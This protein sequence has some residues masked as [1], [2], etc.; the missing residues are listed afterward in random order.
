ML[1]SLKLAA[2]LIV[3]AASSASAFIVVDTGDN[4]PDCEVDGTLVVITDPT[5]ET[6]CDG[7]GTAPP[8]PCVCDLDAAG[9]AAFVW[10]YRPDAVLISAFPACAAGN[11]GDHLSVLDPMDSADCTVGSGTYAPHDCTCDGATST[12]RAGWGVQSEV[13]TTAIF[14]KDGPEV[15]IGTITPEE[16]LD[17][18]GANNVFI[19]IGCTG[20]D[21]VAGVKLENLDVE[22]KLGIEGLGGALRIGDGSVP[23]IFG[24]Q[25]GAP[26]SSFFI[27][28]TGDVCIGCVTPDARLDIVTATGTG[29]EVNAPGPDEVRINSTTGTRSEISFELAGVEKGGI[30]HTVHATAGPSLF[31]SGDGTNDH[32]LLDDTGQLGIG[33]GAIDEPLHIVRADDANAKLECT[34]TNCDTALILAGD[35]VTWRLELAGATDAFRLLIDGVAVITVE[36]N[37]PVNSLV[38]EAITGDI[39]MGTSSPGAELHVSEATASLIVGPQTSAITAIG[40]ETGR[41]GNAYF[42]LRDDSAA[43]TFNF[44]FVIFNTKDG[45]GGND[46]VAALHF[47]Q[48]TTHA[49]LPGGEIQFHTAADGSVIAERMVLEAD[50]DL[51]IASCTDP[52]HDFKIGGTGANCDTG[53]WSEIDAG[54]SSFTISSSRDLKENI[55]PVSRPD[56][57]A[58]ISAIEVSTFKYRDVRRRTVGGD[59]VLDAN[60]ET[61]GEV[62]PPGGR[63]IPIRDENGLPIPEQFE[64]IPGPK[65]RMG[66]M[67][68]DF[69]TIFGRG[70]NTSINGD[71]VRW[72]MWLS[73]QALIKEVNSLKTRVETLESR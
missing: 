28:S 63:D 52:D 59:P 39:G 14:L 7:G 3:A 72:T 27:E 48:A 73:I 53:T 41:S 49:T 67:A 5:S 38:I 25:T 60:R 42:R 58:A 1:K 8:H 21:C 40:I 26:A 24:I 11:D 12:W 22:W 65:D 36:D 43:S 57:L 17:I 70:S 20:A 13:T 47:R 46:D 29:L 50:G 23:D 34:G 10:P 4:L 54:Q 35:A 31:F 32:M 44:G 15:G 61:T 45:G 68:E 56:I 16:I 19:R 33:T 51:G 6:D 9:G 69:H 66:V 64:I 18:E 37:S 30:G 71:E 55:V 2:F 62:E